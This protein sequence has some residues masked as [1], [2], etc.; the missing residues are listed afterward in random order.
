M[1]DQGMSEA[2]ILEAFV[3]Q[4]GRVVLTKLPAEGFNLLA[5]TMPFVVIVLGLAMIW[6]F[7]RRFRKPAVE[8]PGDSETLARYQERIEEDLSKLD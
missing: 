1:L 6:L 8:L 2:S 7:V 3:N 4:Y 5:W